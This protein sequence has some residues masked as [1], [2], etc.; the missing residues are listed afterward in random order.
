MGP[1][2]VVGQMFVLQVAVVVL[3]AI[4]AVVML[5]LTLQRESTREGSDRS[6]AV[7]EGFANSPGIAEALKSRDPTAVLQPRAEAARKGSGVD[8]VVVVNRDGIRYTHPLP[9]RIGKRTNENMAPLLA[10]QTTRR[11]IRGTLG[12]QIRAFVP[13]E[14]PDGSMIGAVGA[15]ITV[16]HVSGMVTDQLPAVLGATAAAVAVTTGGAALLS[17][18]LLR[19]THGLGPAEI[20][21][22]YEH[23]DAVLHSVKEGVLTVDLAEPVLHGEEPTGTERELRRVAAT[24]IRDDPPLYPTGEPIRYLSST[25][26]VPRSLPLTDDLDGSHT[27]TTSP[28][29]PNPAHTRPMT[30]N[31]TMHT[32]HS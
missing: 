16:K 13:V 3:L 26:Q 12:P 29:I 4:G 19:Q 18:R 2:R 30:C 6:L 17:R 1:S 32:A 8:S 23:H 14:E 28:S 15:G 22:M 9:D 11:E 10:G 5:V 24:G 31:F 20:T 21:R 7:A 25:R 27:H